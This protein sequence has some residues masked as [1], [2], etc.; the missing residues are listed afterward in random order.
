MLPIELRGLQ[1]ICKGTGYAYFRTDERMKR[2]V[3][4]IKNIQDEYSDLGQVLS[5]FRTKRTAKSAKVH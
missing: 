5:R 1:N 3:E 2:V 4:H